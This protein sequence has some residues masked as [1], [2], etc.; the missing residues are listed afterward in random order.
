MCK[1]MPGYFC[2]FSREP[3]TARYEHLIDTFLDEGLAEAARDN[4]KAQLRELD[5]GDSHT[6]LAQYLAAIISTGASFISE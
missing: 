3:T 5:L 4:L 6:Y 1:E 2:F